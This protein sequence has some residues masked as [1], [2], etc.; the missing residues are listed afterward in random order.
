MVRRETRER[1]V[2]IDWLEMYVNEGCGVDYTADGFRSRGYDVQERAYGTKTMEEMFVV[3]DNHGHP[4][5]EI[6][7]KPRGLDSGAKQL[8]YQEG[9]SYVK[10]SNIPP[11]K[12]TYT[13]PCQ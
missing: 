9:D 11:L 12:L 2:G 6:R 3:L 10:L 8:V 5:V 13:L 4:F 7:R 1:I